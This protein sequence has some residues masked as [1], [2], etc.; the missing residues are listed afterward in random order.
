MPTYK[1]RAPNGKTYQIDGPDGA[2]DEQIR[3]G[4]LRQHPDA[5]GRTTL[6][7]KA[8]GNAKAAPSTQRKPTNF[9]QG[10]AEEAVRV[11]N[12]MA[13]YMDTL[14]PIQRAANALGLS[15]TGRQMQARANNAFARSPNQGSE[16]GK[17]VGAMGMTLPFAAVRSPVL[18]GALSGAVLAEDP[19]DLGSVAQSA[20]TG[21]AGGKA[22]DLLGRGLSRIASPVVNSIVQRLQAR[23]IPLTPGQ[24]AG[25][26]SSGI[27]NAFKRMEDK[28]M[29][30]PGLGDVISNARRR[31]FEAFNRSAA[32]EALAPIGKALPKDIA[33][34][35][36]AV[37][38]VGDTLGKS[39]D[40][41]LPRMNATADQQFGQDLM[42]IARDA[43][44]L[45]EARGRQFANILKSDVAPHIDPQTHAVTGDGLKAIESRL[46][47]RIRNY[48]SSSDPDARDM[49]DLL[50]AVQAA[51]RNLAAR[52]NPAEA[53][54]LA[55]INKGWAV[56]TRIEQAAN[57]AKEGMFSPAQLQTATRV[58]DKTVRKRASARGTALM[59]DFAEDARGVLP[60]EYP[61]SGTA[62]RTLFALLAGGG[63]ASA[64]GVPGA[65]PVTGAALGAGL[66]AAMPYTKAGQKAAT[67][68]LTGRQ[69]PTA[70]AVAK[71][72]ED[73]TPALT[74]GGAVGAA[75]AGGQ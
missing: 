29:S 7:A 73:F 70:K 54:E 18:G 40:D 26:G 41:L 12:N 6:S 69:G 2:S 22:G 57:S 1:I 16:A 14:N 15:P 52:H 49:A 32:D 44:T 13:T 45:I 17:F 19:E 46:G 21:A 36:Q 38:Y 27:G 47:E 62:G 9:W 56:L 71:L 8:S 75:Q 67:W 42:Q 55:N 28:A 10:A 66:T 37:A 51:S 11:S 30:I 39:Y 43:D 60:S 65:A 4:V 34:G 3:A 72:L 58:A 50:R 53:A 24:I 35:H 33:P 31:G 5:G 23:G 20:A 48:G 59:Q 63:G 61:D 64:M 25:A 74:L 68:A